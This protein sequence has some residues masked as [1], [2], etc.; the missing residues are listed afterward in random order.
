MNFTHDE[1][2]IY[3]NTRTLYMRISLAIGSTLIAYTIHAFSGVVQVE[4]AMI[5]LQT[6]L[7][8]FFGGVG[9][10]FYWGDALGKVAVMDHRKENNTNI[11]G[12]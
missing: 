4:A 2:E 5:I 6:C 12:N 3:V 9:V 1:F 8:L 7:I 11:T 10:G